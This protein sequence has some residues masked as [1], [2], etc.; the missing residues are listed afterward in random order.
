MSGSERTIRLVQIICL[1]GS[2]NG[3]SLSDLAQECQVSARTIY[4]DLS[5]LA[6]GGV[7]FFLDPQTKKYRVYGNAF[8]KP[9]SF[10]V[11][12]ATALVCCAQAFLKQE[13]ILAMPLRRALTRLTD[14]LTDERKTAVEKR[15]CA[16]DIAVTIQENGTSHMFFTHIQ[17]AILEQQQVK[18]QYYSKTRDVHTER[19]IDPYVITFRGGTWYLIAYCHMQNSERIFRID[20]IE[21]LELLNSKFV[22]PATFSTDEFFNGSWLLEQGD[23]V[24][25]KLRFSPEAARWLRDEQAHPSQKIVDLPDGSLIYEVT[26]NGTREITRW[27]LGYG[28][29]VE[30]FEPVGLR[31]AVAEQAKKMAGMY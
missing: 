23:P 25:V 4:R 27:I 18:L 26:V 16:V 29:Q 17:N 24:K 10:Q 6:E 12:E 31:E 20:R 8:L 14:G 30:V 1:I 3:M 22:M 13:S 2:Y 15:S 9:L 21:Q 7:S 5:V 19:I 11:E 28:D